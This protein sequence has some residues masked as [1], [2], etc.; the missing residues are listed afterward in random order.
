MALLLLYRHNLTCVMASALRSVYDY[1]LVSAALSAGQPIPAAV[2]TAVSLGEKVATAYAL[3]SGYNLITQKSS[4]KRK[5]MPFFGPFKKQKIASYKKLVRARGSRMQR[6]LQFKGVHTFKRN[7]AAFVNWSPASGFAIGGP[8]TFDKGV[9]V[10][11]SLQDLT[12]KIGAVSHTIAIPGAT[13]LATLF[14]AWRIKSIELKMFSSSNSTAIGGVVFGLPIIVSSVD[15][16][17]DTVPTSRDEIMQNADAKH[18]QMT[19]GRPFYRKWQPQMTTASVLGT[20]GN[21]AMA[22]SDWVAA[23][24]ATAK[25]LGLKMW[26][27][28]TGSSATPTVAALFNVYVSVVFECKDYQ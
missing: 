3:K 25:Y 1:Q 24:N 20:A 14:D 21:V 2:Y 7:L 27:E 17:D 6:Q 5:R 23:T 11:C 10:T 4:N 16:N 19:E 28:P 22:K 18:H 8:G 15:L 9:S 13:D 12:F 26:S